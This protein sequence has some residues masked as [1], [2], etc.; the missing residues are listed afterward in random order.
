MVQ[1][2]INR[3]VLSK[4]TLP[5]SIS[6][7]FITRKTGIGI[8][9]IKGISEKYIVYTER[10]RAS[11]HFFITNQILNTMR[12]NSLLIFILIYVLWQTFIKHSDQPY[13]KPSVLSLLNPLNS[14]K[15]KKW[16]E[17]EKY[18]KKLKMKIESHVG[19]RRDN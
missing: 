1:N 9:K 18:K 14:R 16:K 10:K 12:L 13:Q 4:N 2:N 15:E 19:K 8:D 11:Y 6:H 17:N 3:N 7:G 5:A